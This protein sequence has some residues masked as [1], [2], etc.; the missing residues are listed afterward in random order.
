MNYANMLDEGKLKKGFVVATL[1][2]TLVG[3]FTGGLALV[4]KVQDKRAE[5]KQRGVDAGQN[6][7]LK[8]LQAKVEAMEVEDKDRDSDSKS[9]R[10]SRRRRRRS[11]DEDDESLAYSVRKSRAMIEREYEDNLMRVG[12]D[13]AR[14][15]LITEN[16]LQAQIIQ[17]QQTVINVLQDALYS[18]R[19]LTKDDTH[20]LL[21]AQ[22]A[23]REGSLEALQGQCKRMLH[24]QRPVEDQ[25][26][27]EPAPSLRA[28]QLSWPVEEPAKRLQLSQPRRAKTL[29]PKSLF[30]RYSEDLQYDSIALHPA[31][32][33]GDNGRCPACSESLDIRLGDSW[34]FRDVRINDRY[35]VKS[36][37][38]DG[39]FVCL[40]CNRNSNVD[41]VCRD[42][43]SL[44]RHLV[45]MHSPEDL[46]DDIDIDLVVRRREIEY[47]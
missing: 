19:Q 10:G 11:Y 41:C 27:L 17:L 1:V 5:A 15:D 16:T 7:Q 13:Y 28:K 8:Q 40:I 44:M 26:L 31:F 47:S 37:A 4:E 34:I 30:C 23:A 14:G 3:T 18:G 21:E 45:S 2:S 24:H 35:V 9:S 46:K 36:H 25:Y 39:R 12:G 32:D 42:V 6:A 29:S 38:E 20:K 22:R 33:P 43:D